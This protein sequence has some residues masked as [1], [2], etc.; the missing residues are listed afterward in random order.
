MDPRIA[1]TVAR[2][3]LTATDPSTFRG[4]TSETTRDIHQRL[5]LG[6]MRAYE[7]WDDSKRDGWTRPQKRAGWMCPEAHALLTFAN[8]DVCLTVDADGWAYRERFGTGDPHAME[9][10][11]KPADE[12]PRSATK[13]P[14]TYDELLGSLTRM[15][16]AYAAFRTHHNEKMPS[17]A[18][19][20]ARHL[21]RR[22]GVEA[23]RRACLT[24]PSRPED[25]A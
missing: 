16:A 23:L 13:P 7:L 14:P 2:F 10:S 5:P 8:G 1:E 4:V 21:I 11:A 12:K 6:W 24:N 25:P 17:E 9:R 20:E 3:G 19:V 18:I 15:T 22:A